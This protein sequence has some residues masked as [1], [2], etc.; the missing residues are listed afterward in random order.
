M[1]IKTTYQPPTIPRSRQ[2]DKDRGERQQKRDDKKRQPDDR[3][4]NS[5]DDDH[6]RIDTYA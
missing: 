6:D 5:G 3:A 4:D 2:V 1:E